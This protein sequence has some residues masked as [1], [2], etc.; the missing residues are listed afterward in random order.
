MSRA[1]SRRA[2]LRGS[3]AASLGLAAGIAASQ[4][5]A[6]LPN[7][8]RLGIMAD[9]LDTLQVHA[10]HH[11][12]GAGWDPRDPYTLA[13]SEMD[14]VAAG[15]ASLPADTMGGV[16]IKL[17]AMAVPIIADDDEAHGLALSICRDLRRFHAPKPE[18]VSHG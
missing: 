1:V 5:A 17:R 6:P 2:A 16:L 4:A 18:Q 10:D 14:L 3:V 15:M 9:R 8:R 11:A 7:D 13:V 12:A